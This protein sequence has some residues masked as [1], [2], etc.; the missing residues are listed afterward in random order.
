MS[1]RPTTR[2]ATEADAPAIAV[3]YNQGIAE[4]AATFEATPRDESGIVALITQLQASGRPVVVVEQS[5]RVVGVAWATPYSQREAYSGVG[6]FS[7]YI[8]REHRRAGLGALVLRRLMAE[9]EERGCWKL[10]SRIFPENQASLALCERLGFRVVGTHRRH[11]RLDGE[12]RD[13]VV[14]ERLLGEA[15]EP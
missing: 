13:C 8:H 1:R 5:H 4:R 7:V 2:L 12:W 14:V 6:E 11:G 9:C 10:L 15:L 3:V